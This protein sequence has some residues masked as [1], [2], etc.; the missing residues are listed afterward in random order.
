MCSQAVRPFTASDLGLL[1]NARLQDIFAA[2]LRKQKDDPF[3]DFVSVPYGTKIWDQK[4]L[5]LPSIDSDAPSV[6]R[7]IKPETPIIGLVTRGVFE[8]YETEEC[9]VS[10]TSPSTR[11]PL[12]PKL[13]RRR[14]T[15]VVLEPGM[16]FGL[17]EAYAHWKGPWT[18]VSGV[19]SFLV[20]NPCGNRAKWG[21]GHRNH[22][23]EDLQFDI[24]SNCEFDSLIPEAARHQWTSDCVLFAPDLIR[25]DR[26]RLEVEN[27]LKQ[28]TIDQLFSVIKQNPTWGG[29]GEVYAPDNLLLFL[30]YLDSVIEGRTPI[31]Q[32][33][34]HRDESQLP[35]RALLQEL[36]L[37]GSACPSRDCAWHILV[38][39]MLSSG[40]KGMHPA[41]LISRFPP[42]AGMALVNLSATQI[43]EKG[44]ELHREMCISKMGELP[45]I[46]YKQTARVAAYDTRN[47][48][49]HP[50][51]PLL[52]GERQMCKCSWYPHLNKVVIVE[53]AD[54]M[55]S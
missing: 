29:I 2:I 47:K 17:F 25:D 13:R 5:M 50:I 11:A 18:I 1:K 12:R 16:L 37:Y 24:R 51:A 30:E 6:L 41:N 40:G 3:G 52:G 10:G 9:Y 14:K 55:V 43:L 38:P 7:H 39:R 21:K 35:V 44:R 42:E 20:C 8:V 53:R 31:F 22:Q 48:R 27:I 49:I 45:C 54:S 19:V 46:E 32:L 4:R 15:T 34:D 33:L 28:A 23:V 26:L 36:T